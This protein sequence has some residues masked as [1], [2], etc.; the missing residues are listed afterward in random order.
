MI[1]NVNRY[2]NFVLARSL[3]AN[4]G[5]IGVNESIMT[6]MKQIWTQINGYFLEMNSKRCNRPFLGFHHM[7]LICTMLRHKSVEEFFT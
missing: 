1:L 3:R 5:R 7:S 2:A 6:I 4:K